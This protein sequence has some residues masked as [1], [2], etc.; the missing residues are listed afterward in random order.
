[1]SG[2]RDISSRSHSRLD[3]F[4]RICELNINLG[5][6]IRS[7]MGESARNA[8]F[9]DDPERRLPREGP[10]RPAKIGSQHLPFVLPI[11]NTIERRAHSR[12]HFME[13]R[14]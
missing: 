14:A 1:V 6:I 10:D 8:A 3:F 9:R 7:R 12:R 13:E 2:S 4:D 11:R 5:V